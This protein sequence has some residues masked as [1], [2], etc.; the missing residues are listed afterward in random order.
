MNTI[1]LF[2]LFFVGVHSRQIFTSVIE[3]PKILRD[4][5]FIPGLSAAGSDEFRISDEWRK[6]AIQKL[7]NEREL[8]T[9]TPIYHLP[10]SF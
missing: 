7:W 9:R 6:N 1:L 5:N 2:I 10:V 3:P 8:M 4:E